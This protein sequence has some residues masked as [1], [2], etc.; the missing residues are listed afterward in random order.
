MPRSPKAP[1]PPPEP[2]PSEIMQDNVAKIKRLLGLDINRLA[3]GSEIEGIVTGG[4][5]GVADYTVTGVSLIE[6]VNVTTSIVIG[7]QTGT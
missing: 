7:T 1:A 5:G 2:T 3:I 4:P 6:F